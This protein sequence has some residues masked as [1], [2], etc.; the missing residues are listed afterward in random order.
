MDPLYKELIDSARGI[1]KE[2]INFRRRLHHNPETGWKE[3]ETSRAI[4]NLLQADGIT[5]HTFSDHAGLYTDISGP[6]K[7]PV[8][9]YRADMDALP[10]HDDKQVT[11]SSRVSGFGH[12]C[13]H[14]VHTTIAAGIARLL[15]ARADRLK[16]TVRIFWQ[17]AEELS[18]GGALQMIKDCVLDRVEGI[19]ALH[20]DPTLE[21]GKFK[22]KSGAETASFDMFKITVNAPETTHSARPHTGKD[23]VWI[24]NQIAQNLYQLPGR[25]S[26]SRDPAVLAICT[27]HG[28]EAFN[29]IPKKVVF[30][31]TVRTSWEEDRDLFREQ[32]QKIGRHAQYLYDTEINVEINRGAPAVINNGNFYKFADAAIAGQIGRQNTKKSRQSMGAE[33]FAYFSQKVPA[34]YV[35][36]GTSCSPETSHPLHSSLFDVDE[37][38]I[39]PTT[40]MMSFLLIQHLEQGIT[41]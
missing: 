34:L 28:G 20:C 18:P 14:D 13:G 17:P 39:A 16:G 11:Y 9:A 5:V 3:Y 36:M 25:Y 32:I 12:M 19:Y 22:L 4:R 8:V 27:F 23:T 24:A 33:D 15:H 41:A 30:G 40:A 1:N 38:V 6:E 37:S 7:E 21:S 31:G 29:V 10:I 35:R 26:D 2:L